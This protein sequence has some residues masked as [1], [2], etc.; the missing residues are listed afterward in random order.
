MIKKLLIC[1]AFSGSVAIMSAQNWHPGYAPLM[2]I[3]G[4]SIKADSVHQEYPRPQMVR[5]EWKNLNGVW[6]YAITPKDINQIPSEYEG[7]I[8]VPFAIESAL[9][10]VGKD[11]TP[12]DK[13]WYET[14]FEVPKDWKGKRVI[15]HFGAVDYSCSVYVNGIEIGSHK[16]S[17]DAFR[18][19][20]TDALEESGDQKLVVSVTDPTDTGFQ[21]VGKQ[22]LK[23]SGIYYTPVSGIWKT[24]WIEPVSPSHIYSFRGIPDI[25]KSEYSITPIT[26]GHTNG[27]TVRV[28]VYE[29]GKEINTAIGMPNC[30]IPVKIKNVK[31]WS[32]ENPFLYDIKI[33]LLHKNKVIDS[34][35]S[36]FGMRKISVGKDGKGTYRIF[37][38]NEPYFLTGL[39]DQG[40]WPDGLLTPA[41]DEALVY[42]IE[43]AKQAGFNTLRKHIKQESDRFYYHC[44]R[45]GMLVLQDAVASKDTGWWKDSDIQPV[46]SEEESIA[47][48]HEFKNMIDQLFNFPCIAEWIVFNEGWGQHSTLGMLEWV[49]FL[50][51]TRPNSIS[52][53]RD[54]GRGDICD[55][56]RYPGPGRMENT[57]GYRP[58]LLGEYGGLGYVVKDHIWTAE[59]T[60]KNY[61]NATD[62]GKY[63]SDYRRIFYQLRILKAQGLAG[64]VYTQISDV[65]GEVNGLMTYDRK[66]CKMPVGEIK[67]LNDLLLNSEIT[68]SEVM[69]NSEKEA[70]IWDYTTRWEWIK[71]GWEK[72]D[73][74]YDLRYWDKG[75]GY[76][77]Y[78]RPM[79]DYNTPFTERTDFA[80]MPK[81]NWN[82]SNIW[83]R[84]ELYLDEVPENPL[85]YI[86][87]YN[88]AEVYINGVKVLE[89]KGR[90]APYPHY[91]Y[92]KFRKGTENILKKGKNLIAVHC[93]KTGGNQ[94]QAIDLGIYNIESE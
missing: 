10:G 8:L 63:A 22:K 37:L 52:G 35:N 83:I 12:E 25:D 77:G 29:N 73:Y 49:K 72:K 90:T 74:D 92:H 33:E 28:T 91:E 30:E 1:I 34:F 47:F 80:H 56:H 55:I 75:P 58:L 7:K 41:S 2:T 89:V 36:Y 9:S 44:D 46:P 26:V 40:W 32:P 79:T 87:Y 21:P 53:W 69:P 50:D 3:W 51:P 78:I 94:V 18:F 17:S 45:L 60:R 59:T 38:N 93:R 81:T 27:M 54:Y 65:E 16:G 61:I 39:L 62:T 57:G 48:T 71:P 84:K 76:F 42:D 64:A 11:F 14:E 6:N 68:L 66:V 19:D 13:L 23:P 4:E 43:F 70:Q 5:D 88:E 67:R 85:L 82:T 31:L 15:L 24:V 20:I 86:W